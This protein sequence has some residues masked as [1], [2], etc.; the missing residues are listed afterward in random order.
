M[1][2]H[3]SLAGRAAGVAAAAVL[4]ASL[5]GARSAAAE[6][7]DDAPVTTASTHVANNTLLIFGTNSDDSVLVGQAG[8]PNQLVVNVN[9][10]STTF[11]RATFDAIDVNLG[12]GDDGFRETAGIVSDERVTVN[13]G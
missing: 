5:A 7:S 8:D 12:D 6:P 11:D 13:A 9:G 1:K 4:I 2:F 10:T 3:H